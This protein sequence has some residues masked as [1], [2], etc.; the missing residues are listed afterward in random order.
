[1]QI[2][3]MPFYVLWE[4]YINFITVNFP[5]LQLSDNALFIG[6]ILINCFFL[7]FIYI[8]IKVLKFVVLIIKNVV[9]R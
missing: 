5:T 6:F 3:H 8:L 9:F 7:I 1:M 4:T 2:N